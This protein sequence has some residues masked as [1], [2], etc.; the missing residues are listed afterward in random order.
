LFDYDDHFTYE[1]AG[2]PIIANQYYPLKKV[3]AID[4]TCRRTYG[5]AVSYRIPNMCWSGGPVIE[6]PEKKKFTFLC[7]DC[8]FTYIPICGCPPAPGCP[9]C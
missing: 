7:L 5:F 2:T 1:D 9:P 6:T 4:N 8:L 3:P